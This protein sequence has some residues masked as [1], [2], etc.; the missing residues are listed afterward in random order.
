MAVITGW[1]TEQTQGGL[2]TNPNL[3]HEFWDYEYVEWQYPSTRG[4][5]TPSTPVGLSISNLPV[6]A[7]GVVKAGWVASSFYDEWYNTIH[8]SPNTLNLG[9]ISSVQSR[10]VY[11]WNAYFEPYD[12]LSIT[13][14]GT[15]LSVSGDTAT[16]V[17][18]AANQE[19]E[20]T[21]TVTL[22]GDTI[23]DSD[24]QFEFTNYIT[25]VTN[26]VSIF[27]TKVVAFPFLIDWMDGISEDLEWKTDVITSDT[28]WEQ[29]RVLRLA[30]RRTLSVD[31][32]LSGRDK[33]IF[34]MATYAWGGSI[35]VIPLWWDIQLTPQAVT[36]GSFYIPCDT[37]YKEFEVGK[38]VMLMGEESSVYEVREIESVDGGGITVTYALDKDWP[39]LSRVYPATTAQL[40][41]QPSMSRVNDRVSSTSCEFTLIA[42]SDVTGVAPT[43]LYRGL[44]VLEIKPDETTNLTH[45]Y[46]RVMQELDSGMSQPY[47]LDLGGYGMEVREWAWKDVGRDKLY[48]LRQFM[49]YLMGRASPVW[50]SSWE[51]DIQLTS[52]VSAGNN[53]LPIENIGYYRFGGGT[54]KRHIQVLL[55]DG[56][57]YYR[58]I[59]SYQLISDD[60]ENLTLNEALPVDINPQ[61][62]RRISFITLS[63]GSSDSLTINH[64]TDSDGVAECS[65]SFTAIKGE[66]SG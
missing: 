56:S 14:F 24:I 52:S 4:S 40:T 28:G 17:S 3:S 47:T 41:E 39:A 43:T 38:Y 49:Y 62:V 5:I 25:T 16:P 51:E 32:T 46:Q 7:N 6:E 23:V 36:A 8:I 63:R 10:S 54:H 45:Q 61:N 19:R 48:K 57:M 21:I 20:Y 9:N 64:V 27:G 50:I 1:L 35:F 59:E 22:D 30:P 29:R 31:M 2:T 60:V 37:V 11:V 12:L 26:S 44:P 58:S 33:R 53:T 55:W 65:I 13:G 66:G 15:G 42:P 34:Q 18:F